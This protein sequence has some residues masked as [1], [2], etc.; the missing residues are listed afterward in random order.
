ML[1]K[2]FIQSL[3]MIHVWKIICWKILESF[4]LSIWLGCVIERNL[5]SKLFGVLT[6]IISVKS[7]LSWDGHLSSTKGRLEYLKTH[8]VSRQVLT[9]FQLFCFRAPR[10]QSKTIEKCLK[11]CL[12]TRLS[13]DTFSLRPQMASTLTHFT[14]WCPEVSSWIFRRDS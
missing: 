12:K 6:A 8:P 7:L 2:E 13:S 4:F 9:H 11:T 5:K 3:L 14:I 1:W 10:I